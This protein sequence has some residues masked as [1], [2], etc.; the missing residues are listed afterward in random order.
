MAVALASL[1]ELQVAQMLPDI[2]LPPHHGGPPIS[3]RPARSE[4]SVILWMHPPG[5]RECESYLK[6]LA[7]IRDEFRVWEGRLLVVS[8]SEQLPAKGAGVIVADRYGQVFHIALAGP[9]HTLPPP[10]EL[11]EWL[12][13][14]GTLCPE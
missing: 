10:R 12:K 14:L 13:F 8:G 4:T 1:D 7:E 2:E 6:S 5:C 3:L 11:A 9:R